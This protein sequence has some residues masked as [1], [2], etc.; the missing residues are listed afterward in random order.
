MFNKKISKGGKMARVKNF[1]L[2][3]L[4][5][6]SFLFAQELLTNGDF[7]QPLEVGWTVDT[8]G[9]YITINRDPNLQPDPDYEALVY[10]LYTGY[11]SIYQIVDL[12][13]LSYDFSFYARFR[14]K[15]G[16][17]TCWPVSAVIIAYLDAGNNLLGETRVYYPSPYCNW[18]AG[19]TLHLVLVTDTLWNYYYF[20]IRDD[21]VHN[22]PGVDTAQVRKAKVS[23]YAYNSGG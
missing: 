1:F 4:L 10:K 15:E 23:L 13:N 12:P 18:Q 11:A 5:L 21:I 17:S 6:S 9:G 7:E 22:L 14:K 2:S 16:S 3:L 20:N 8:S 19:P